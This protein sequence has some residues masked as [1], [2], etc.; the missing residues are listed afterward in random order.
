MGERKLQGMLIV[1]VGLPASG[2]TSW[3]KGFI[4]DNKDKTIDI[5]SSDKIREEMFNDIEDQNHN[6][7]VFD[8]MKRRT[9]ESLSQGHIVVYEATNISSKRRRALLKELNKY[10]D[11]AI[12]LFKY[13]N[14]LNCLVDN[15]NRKK[16]VPSDVINRMYRNFEIPHKNEGFD[17]IIVDFDKKTNLY[18]GNKSKGG[19]GFLK[20]E[21]LAIETYGDYKKLLCQL[22]LNQCVDMPQDSKWHTLSLSRHMYFCFRAVREC[23]WQD[24]N[25]VI[26][27]MLHDISKPKVRTED[28]DQKYAHYYGHENASAY[29]VIDILLRYV[30]ID[31]EDIL[32]IAWLIGNH[33][34]LKKNIDKDKFSNIIGYDDYLRLETLGNA[35]NSAK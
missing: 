30:R 27:S 24:T 14:L 32:E 11:K 16:R 34:K 28:E 13:K 3:V 33:M 21:L 20:D 26:A 2:K 19:I 10:Y 7:E 8:I 25:L 6:G 9:K 22:G 31:T 29:D 23:Y 35:D 1:T 5:I 15:E 12:C 18:L 17:E 4:E